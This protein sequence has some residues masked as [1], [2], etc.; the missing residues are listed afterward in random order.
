[1]SNSYEYVKTEDLID[2]IPKPNGVKIVGGCVCNPQLENSSMSSFS[3]NFTEDKVT[4]WYD[5]QTSDWDYLICYSLQSRTGLPSSY[6]YSTPIKNIIMYKD[7]ISNTVSGTIFC[8]N[9]YVYGGTVLM[10]TE[11]FQMTYHLKNNTIAFGKY[12]YT[13]NNYGFLTGPVQVIAYKYID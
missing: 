11:P 12:W 13:Q 8:Y 9:E 6:V 5:L 1:M 4:T 2:L 10:F 3:S 7:N